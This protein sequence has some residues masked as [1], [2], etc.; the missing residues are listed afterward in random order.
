MISEHWNPLPITQ[1]IWVLV[2]VT[3]K[4]AT[5]PNANSDAKYELDPHSLGAVACVWI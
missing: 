5:T 2:S 1:T 3:K 4:A